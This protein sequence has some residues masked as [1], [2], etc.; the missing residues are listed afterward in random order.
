MENS[1][2]T[3]QAPRIR[4]L[5]NQLVNQIAA[6]EIVERP[7]SILK[8]LLEN[9]LDAGAR[10]IVV[11]LE[12]GGLRRISVR[13]DGHG[14]R[15][16]CLA[17]AMGRHAT[18]KIRNQNDLLNVMTMGFRGEALPSMGSVSRMT[19]T[20][21]A[22]GSEYAWKILYES[23]ED[24][25]TPE[26]AAHPQGTSIEIC[27]LFYNT[28]ARRK[29]LR[30]EKTEYKH[31]DRR[32]IEQALARPD[33][34]FRLFHDGR[35]VRSMEAAEDEAGRN[36]RVFD[37]LGKDF[38]ENCLFIDQQ[39]GD[40]HV[41]GWFSQ[42]T[43]SRSQR[44]QQFFY[45]NRR[46]VRDKLLMHAVTQA[47]R[48]VLHHQRQPAFVLFLDLPPNQ[49][50]VNVHPGKHEVRFREDRQIHGFISQSLKKMLTDT[51]PGA[52]P[53]NPFSETSTE[54]SGTFLFAQR[55]VEMAAAPYSVQEQMTGLGK[56]YFAEGNI[57]PTEAGGDEQGVAKDQQGNDFSLSDFPL[58]FALA[59]LQGIYILAENENGLVIVD[60]HAAYERIRYEKLK[61]QLDKEPL[62]RQP[63]L[64]PVH[65]ALSQEE[66]S[67]A[68]L[69]ISY[70]NKIGFEVDV[71]TETSIVIRSVPEMLA[72][73]D[74]PS[75][76][77]DI[78]SDLAEHGR[79]SRME[80]RI[81]EI[82]STMACHGSVRAN[83]L[84]TR[85]EMNALLREM[86]QTERSNQ[87]NHGRPTWKQ[88]TIRELDKMF[89]R[90]Q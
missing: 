15:Q 60:M 37:V 68:E 67:L 55:H 76:I 79:S 23:N 25:P 4:Q 84:L 52:M 40:L 85:E 72:R 19:I 43:Y 34:G 82:L 33:V 89:M 14:I 22:R 32:F 77:R 16:D 11:E 83:R 70:F 5:P 59:Q 18:S 29:F 51:R 57:D 63:L 53:A 45:V 75:L 66:I 65:L 64:V 38:I 17:L 73:V 61:S 44:D 50:D 36:K 62:A 7:A 49:V 3:N 46:Y 35:A 24:L 48:D 81:N 56:L 30:T 2:G 74:I 26:P 86:E 13:D 87:C 47:Y 78:L 88:L 10:Q 27:D 54:N 42:P 80:D 39:T 9:S 31:L 20:S 6:G 69:N 1:G 41:H 71:I 12:H 58:G 21:R 28:P 90:G 8:E